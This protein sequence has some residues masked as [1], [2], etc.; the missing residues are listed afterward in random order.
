MRERLVELQSQLTVVQTQLVER[1][2]KLVEVRAECD[3]QIIALR[4]KSRAE[5]ESLQ[6]EVLLQSSRAAYYVAAYSVAVPIAQQVQPY[7]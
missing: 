3:R 2:Q 4:A 5:I 1:D 6:Q 7:S